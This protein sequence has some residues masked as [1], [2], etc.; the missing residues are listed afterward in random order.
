MKDR[1]ATI[2]TTIVTEIIGIVGFLMLVGSFAY[3][4]IRACLT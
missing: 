1:I 2:V 3:G 4:I